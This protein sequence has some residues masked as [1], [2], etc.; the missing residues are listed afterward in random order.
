MSS[1]SPV[2]SVVMAVHN[3][4]KYLRAA[5][6]SIL[7]QSFA[8]FEFIVIDD[9]STDE[10]L[11]IL[12]SYDDP[13]LRIVRRENKGLTKSLNEGI[14]LARGE[15]IARMDG[16]DIAL[17]QRFEKQVALLRTDDSL[18]AVGGDVMRIDGDDRPLTSP[19][20]PL[21]H[22]EIEADLLLGRGG[23]LVHPAM[24]AR[25]SALRAIGGYREQ[26]KTA[27]DLDLY[28]RLVKRGKLANVPEVV[29]KYRI[30]A[31]SVSA[32]KREQQ[33]RDVENIL[34]DAYTARGQSLPREVARRRYELTVQHYSREFW[35][36]WHRRE[37]KL[38][39]RLAWRVIRKAPLRR[40]SWMLLGYAVARDP[41]RYPNLRQQYAE[42]H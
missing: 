28:L 4:A 22:D 16:D 34:R 39:R 15:L 20:M 11:A 25:A 2:I 40:D 30:H 36:A 12:K 41:D 17:P 42:R 3:G 14:A 38:A 8:D 13:R 37:P 18:V 19:R 5:V 1:A 33:D 35:S 24:M 9:G 32:A 31:N 26:F 29:L 7:A 6:D 10:S 23:A 21:T 27:Q